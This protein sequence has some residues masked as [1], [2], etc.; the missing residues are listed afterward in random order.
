MMRAVAG[1]HEAVSS[2][3]SVGGML[4]ADNCVLSELLHRCI[5]SGI[6]GATD[7]AIATGDW[8]VAVVLCCSRVGKVAVTVACWAGNKSVVA[9]DDRAQGLIGARR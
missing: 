5:C 2:N 3:E 6:E 7:R 4:D 9:A 8:T 1:S